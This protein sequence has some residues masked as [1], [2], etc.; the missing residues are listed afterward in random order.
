MATDFEQVRGALDLADCFHAMTGR[1]RSS[2]LELRN[3]RQFIRDVLPQAIERIMDDWP[4]KR[5]LAKSGNKIALCLMELAQ[6]TAAKLQ[7]RAREAHGSTAADQ[8]NHDLQQ[9]ITALSLSWDDK[10]EVYNKSCCAVAFGRHQFDH[11][12]WRWAASSDPEQ[13][14]DQDSAA[15]D[16]SSMSAEYPTDG[17]VERWFQ[18]MLNMFGELRGFSNIFSVRLQCHLQ[19]QHHS[20]ARP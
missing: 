2:D 7:E 18:G 20:Q 1:C 12:A 5:W 11:K 19:P 15:D 6:V 9:L 3:C 14:D 16:V 4:N 17:P 10:L 8:H 13:G